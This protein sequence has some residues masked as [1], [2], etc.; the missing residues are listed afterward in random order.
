[1]DDTNINLDGLIKNNGKWRNK[2]ANDKKIS[3]IKWIE[4]SLTCLTI[5]GKVVKEIIQNLP[6]KE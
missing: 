5:I 2:M 3:I 1:M 4:F 6:E